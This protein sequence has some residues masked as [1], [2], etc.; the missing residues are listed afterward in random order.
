MSSQFKQRGNGKLWQWSE[1]AFKLLQFLGN[2]SHFDAALR[3][4]PHCNKVS[5]PEAPQSHFWKRNQRLGG[6]TVWVITPSARRGGRKRWGIW[7]VW[8]CSAAGQWVWSL[9]G[10]TSLRWILMRV[11]ICYFT[12]WVCELSCSHTQCYLQMKTHTCR[13]SWSSSVLHPGEISMMFHQNP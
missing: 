10:V 11:S 1:K 8:V 6:P 7:T 5:E 2:R 3:T 4:K 12:Q 9:R 13:H